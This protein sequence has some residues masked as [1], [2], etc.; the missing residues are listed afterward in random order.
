[1]PSSKGLA[2]DDVGIGESMRALQPLLLLLVMPVV[3]HA[4]TIACTTIDT[5]PYVITQPG[6]Y[7]LSHS[8]ANSPSTNTSPVIL[9][10]QAIDVTLDCNHHR[11]TGASV[12]TAA[13][14]DAR[15]D[16]GV[17]LNAAGRTT[18]RNCHFANL[19][20][21]IVVDRDNVNLLRPRD[22]TIEDNTT[23]GVGYGLIFTASDGT[24]FIRRNVFANTVV[25]GINASA[26]SGQLFVTGNSVL[27]VGDTTT[28][29]GQGGYFYANSGWTIVEDNLFAEIVAPPGGANTNAVTLGTSGGIGLVFNRNRVLAPGNPAEKGSVTVGIDNAAANG[30][31]ANLTVG[32]GVTPQANC[33]VPTNLQY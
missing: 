11:I 28:R 16:V 25:R 13:N 14:V 15:G 29:A 23:E 1:M 24:S 26:G 19:A 18:V 8:L 22:I 5:A 31:E 3:C 6:T 27:R 9:V 30:C 10:E 32:Y 33:P 17:Y 4:E 21:G 7:C 20:G 2:G 12:V